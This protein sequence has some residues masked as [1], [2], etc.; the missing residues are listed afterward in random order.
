MPK[1]LLINICGLNK[2]KNRVQAPV[3]LAV[4]MIATDVDICIVSET[5]LKPDIPDSVV[6]IS[7]YVLHRRDQNCFGNDKRAEGLRSML[8]VTFISKVLTD[9]TNMNPFQSL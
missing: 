8:G 3:A 2:T 7:N 5:H 1:C 9:R 6:A 4:D